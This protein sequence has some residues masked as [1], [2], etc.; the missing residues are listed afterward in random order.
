MLK[1]VHMSDLHLV[2]PDRELHGLRPGERLAACV[3]DIARDHGDAAFCVVS[4]DLTHDGDPLAYAEAAQI[5][6][7]LP[8]PVH[9]MIGNHDDRDAFR[10]AFPNAPRDRHGFVQQVIDTSAGRLILL[11]THEPGRPEGRL[12]ERQLDWL[13]EAIETSS[14][15]LFLFM[16]HPPFRVGFDRMDRIR[17]LD[18]DALA[19]VIGQAGDRVRHLFVGHLHR[20]LAGS[21]RGWPF[22]GVRGTSHQIALDFT[23]R[24]DAPV[25]FE[26]P[27]YAIVRVDA[28]S[29]VVHF[30]EAGGRKLRPTR[31]SSLRSSINPDGRS[32]R[33]R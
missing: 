26:A 24:S 10:Q 6:S 9:L 3:E 31:S 8:M 12:C 2:P 22:S 25:S 30:A 27:G 32:L 16:H 5:L 20:D 13:G 7:R 17:L 23:K 21:W 18:A 28:E 33:S 11:D 15:P 14:G 1:F 19:A 4:G 29:V